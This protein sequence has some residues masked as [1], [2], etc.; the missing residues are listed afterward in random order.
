VNGQQFHPYQQIEQSPFTLNQ[1]TLKKTTRYD[2]GNPRP[3][4]EQAQKCGRVK[5]V[6]RTL[7]FLII[8]SFNIY[9]NN[10]R[11]VLEITLCDKVC[12]VSYLRQVMVFSGFLHQ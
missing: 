9:I 6:K 3:G 1:W 10:C 7:P 4:L 5:P 8:T 2:V 11:G 12:L